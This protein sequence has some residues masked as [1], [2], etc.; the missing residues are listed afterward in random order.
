V[1]QLLKAVAVATTAV[2]YLVLQMG[3]LVTNTGSGNGCGEHWPLCKGTFMP[4][5]D[6][7]AIIEFS[8]RAVSGAAGMLTVLLLVWVWVVLPKE[9]LLKWLTAGALFFVCLQGALGA[10][11]VLWPQPTAILALH[12][13]VSLIC[14]SFTLWLTMVLFRIDTNAGDATDRASALPA[15]FR[16]WVWWVAIF[17]YGVVYLGAF[18]RHMKASL[19]CVGWPLCNGELIPSLYGLT[20]ISFMHR[21]GAALAAILVIRTVVL[22]SRYD[23]LRPGIR[24]TAN[25]A[26]LLILAQVVS[27]AVIAMG[28]LNL[29]T[30]MTHSA[31]VSLYWGAL[32]VLCLQVTALTAR[33]GTTPAAN[34]PSMPSV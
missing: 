21:L 31:I 17:N 28:N 33:T 12:F 34:A 23:A 16:R 30:R 15:E 24:R 2:M 4:D 8:H 10:A 13:G 3:A 19:A 29:M 7:A 5:W 32:T 22:A 20:G 11:A 14:F 1:N 6:Y 27:G 26:L 9:R 18:V 25:V